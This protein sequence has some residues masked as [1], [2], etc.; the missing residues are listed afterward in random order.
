[1][2]ICKNCGTSYAEHVA[3]CAQCGSNL[4]MFQQDPQPAYNAYDAAAPAPT[5]T[6]SYEAPTTAA[7]DNKVPAILSLVF[8]AI[9]AVIALSL[10][11]VLAEY[12][13]AS[14]Y[15][16]YYYT[17]SYDSE[18]L[19]AF[20]GC[21]V[22]IVPGAILGMIMSGKTQALKGMSIAGKISSIVSLGLLGLAFF[23][24]IGVCA[25]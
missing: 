24:M 11:G 22:F 25:M 18:A 7:S 23:L 13:S 2:Y 15:S 6:Y 21:S 17:P 9:A 5:P 20:F 19:G 3:F 4:M 8:G 12:L 10:I 16:Y 1:M 14:S